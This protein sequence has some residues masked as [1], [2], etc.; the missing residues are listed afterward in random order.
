MSYGTPFVVEADLVKLT[1]IQDLAN[2]ELPAELDLTDLILSAHQEIFRRVE[3]GG[4]DPT[5]L[6]NETRLDSAIAYELVRRL[7]LGGT[8]DPLDD[9]QA[10]VEL[11]ER[12]V[13]RALENFKPATTAADA[14]RHLSDAV[15]AVGNF[16]RGWVFADRARDRLDRYFDTFP[17]TRQA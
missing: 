13:S 17:D 2:L 1:G 8:I 12:E 16:E 7:A 11:F 6:T 14:A 10:S 3:V 15:P 4:T 5:L 9:R